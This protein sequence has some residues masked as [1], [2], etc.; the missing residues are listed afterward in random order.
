MSPDD[1]RQLAAAVSEFGDQEVAINGTHYRVQAIESCSGT[2]SFIVAARCECGV[3]EVAH[4]C[5]VDDGTAK[6]A[7]EALHYERTL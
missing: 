4:W 7:L 5:E 2:V 3:T 6:A 1:L